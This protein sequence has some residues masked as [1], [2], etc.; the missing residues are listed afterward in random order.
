MSEADKQLEE[1]IRKI[2]M[3]VTHEVLDAE[4][5]PILVDSA[6]AEEAKAVNLKQQVKVLIDNQQVRP[7]V[8]S[9]ADTEEI[10]FI[11][12]MGTNGEYEK[13]EDFDNPRFKAL[14]TSLKAHQG[15]MTADGYFLWIFPDGKAI[16]RKRKT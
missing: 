5:W 12:L 4:V 15:K 7:K 9:H 1:K 14:M 11:R 13:S 2:S 6:N 8:D 3:K 10:G 16:G